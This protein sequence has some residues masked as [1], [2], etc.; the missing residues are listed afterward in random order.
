M[1]DPHLGQELDILDIRI[2]KHCTLL[3]LQIPE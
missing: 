1:L 3:M 2:I